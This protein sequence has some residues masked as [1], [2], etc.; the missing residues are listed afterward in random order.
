MREISE[1]YGIPYNTGPLHRQFGSVVRKIVKL[2]L[3]P[4]RWLSKR[5]GTVV[6]RTVKSVLAP[7]PGRGGSDRDGGVAA[8]GVPPQELAAV[9]SS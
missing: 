4:R 1:R 2:A 9:A 7:L 8:A 6:P 5:F 3:P